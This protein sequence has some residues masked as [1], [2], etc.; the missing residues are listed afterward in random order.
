MDFSIYVRK[1]RRCDLLLCFFGELSPPNSAPLSFSRHLRHFGCCSNANQAWGG[2][3][4]MWCWKKKHP[5]STRW[6]PAGYIWSYNPYKWPCK[7]ISL[8]VITYSLIG[9]LNI[10]VKL[11]HPSPAFFE[12]DALRSK[13][14]PLFLVVKNGD[15]SHGIESLYK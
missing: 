10:V 6:A 9:A 13:T 4:P 2:V 5:K 14:Y 3:C 11:N 12:R 15:E 8:G 7:W 1:N